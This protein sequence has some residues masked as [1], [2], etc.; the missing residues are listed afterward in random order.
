MARLQ[1]DDWLVVGSRFELISHGR[2]FCFESVS[3]G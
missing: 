2:R 1:F 3:S